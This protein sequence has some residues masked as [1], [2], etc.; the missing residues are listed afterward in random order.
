MLDLDLAIEL[1]DADGRPLGEVAA[2][3]YASTAT[4]LV[5]CPYHDRRRGVPM[6]AS[7]FDQ[8]RAAWKPLLS[9]AGALSDGTAL[10]A[11]RAAVGLVGAPVLF[12]EQNPGQPVPIEL[13][14]GYKATLGFTQTLTSLLLRAGDRPFAELGTG[15]E[16]FAYLD[17]QGWL[18]GQTQ[19]CAGSPRMIEELWTAL[20]GTDDALPEPWARLGL[21]SRLGEL[22]TIEALRIGSGDLGTSPWRLLSP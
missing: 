20:G 16:L 1:L 8:L 12:A 4:R 9:A 13:S 18:L 3:S 5:R 11:W 21:A 19:A 22:A 2:R 7:A 6:N 14:A 15:A 17:Q 10:G